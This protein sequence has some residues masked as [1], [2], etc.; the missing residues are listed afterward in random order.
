MDDKWLQDQLTALFDRVNE[1]VVQGKETKMGIERLTTTVE[2]LVREVDKLKDNMGDHREEI[3]IV[4]ANISH[5][6]E[7]QE[8]DTK[9][10]W[11]ELDKV[12]KWGHERLGERKR[13]CEIHHEDLDEAV[14][15]T[16]TEAVRD[17]K[18]WIY[19]IIAGLLVM[20]IMASIFIGRTLNDIDMLKNSRGGGNGYYREEKDFDRRGDD[21]RA[22]DRRDS[23]VLH[24]GGSG[25]N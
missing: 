22:V 17:V 4:K 15:I 8:S 11:E 9:M 3:T 25:Q 2:A 1:T 18:L 24:A 10:I 16:R 19:G 13:E 6:K 5:L 21:R 23:D 12:W 20:I 7:R 14:T